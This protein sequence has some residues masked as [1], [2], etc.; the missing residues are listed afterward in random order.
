MQDPESIDHWN[1]AMVDNTKYGTPLS[2]F[3]LNE[4]LDHDNL[5][6]DRK[7]IGVRLS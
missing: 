1:I 5:S 2:S 4:I 3:S 7:Y 6:I